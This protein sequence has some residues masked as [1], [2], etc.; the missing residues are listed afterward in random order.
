MRPTQML[1]IA[2]AVVLALTGRTAAA[3]QQEPGPLP[4]TRLPDSLKSQL[5][6]YVVGQEAYFVD[7]VTYAQT[8]AGLGWGY[9]PDDG[10]TVAVLTSTGNAHSA[11]AVHED[12]PSLVCAV[13]V[14]DAPPPLNDGAAEGQATCRIPSGGK[15]YR[16]AAVDVV[17]ERLSCPMPTYPPAQLAA[18]TEGNVLVR[19]I[20]EQDGYVLREFIEVVRSTHEDFVNPA[21]GMIARCR[22]RPGRVEGEPVRVMV[23]MP[24]IF[25]PSRGG[26]S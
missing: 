4:I 23:E 8:V 24:I 17:P 19:F 22:F 6:R 12:W 9:R 15:V 13:R 14:G 5:R 26:G 18:G 25:R 16:E 21:V 10:V 20:T 3:Q 1:A 7:H 2:G 11:I